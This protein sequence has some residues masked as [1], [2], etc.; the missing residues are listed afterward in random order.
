MNCETRGFVH[1]STEREHDVSKNLRCF[2]C[3]DCP[4]CRG[5]GVESIKKTVVRVGARE[6]SLLVA[7]PT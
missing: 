6:S 2:F 4:I 1:T 5:L 7:P 3:K